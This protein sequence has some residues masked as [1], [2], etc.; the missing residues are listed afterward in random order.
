MVLSARE[1]AVQQWGEVKLGDARLNRRVL[2]MGV[3]MTAHPE[4]SLP[5]QMASPSTLKA[6]YGVLNHPG[7]TLDKLTAPHRKQTL[8]RARQ[9]TVVLMVQDTTE[10]DY[11][12]HPSKRGLGPTGDGRGRG[13]L[14][15]STLAI[16]PN[17]RDVLGLADVRV[18]L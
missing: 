3:K 14:L 9:E 17:T 11:T 10:L 8:A 12:A 16:E 2:E 18:V 13:L 6:A 4:A 5:E 7:V 15:H 1:W